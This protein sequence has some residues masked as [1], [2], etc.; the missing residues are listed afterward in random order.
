MAGWCKPENDFSELSMKVTPEEL[1]QRYMILLKIDAINLFNRVKGRQNDY[2]DA[3]SLKRD[4]SIFGDVFKC[5]YDSTTMFDLSH[6]PHEIIEVSNDFYTEVDNL[7]WYLMNTQDMPNAIEDEI[8]R[9]LHHIE[10]KLEVL[11]LYTDAVLSG[12]SLDELNQMEAEV[13]EELEADLDHP[14]TDQIEEFTANYPE[15][16]S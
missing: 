14:I 6:L 1:S 12:K 4:R 10:K 5:R 13:M 2:I 7:H 3:F 15:D 8:I 9:Y 11:I 16:D